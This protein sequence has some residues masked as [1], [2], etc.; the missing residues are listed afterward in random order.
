MQPHLLASTAAAARARPRVRRGGAAHRRGAFKLVCPR[1][2][3][4]SQPGHYMYGHASLL[5]QNLVEP[6]LSQA[7]AGGTDRQAQCLTR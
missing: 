2:F 1:I 5:T 3:P 6:R 4:Q 7:A